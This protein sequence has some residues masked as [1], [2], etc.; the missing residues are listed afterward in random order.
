MSRMLALTVVAFSLFT[1]PGIGLSEDINFDEAFGGGQAVS[2]AAAAGQG[3]ISGKIV[4]EGAPAAE[5]AIKME[6]DPYCEI[7]HPTPI[8]PQEVVANAN[9]TLKNVFVYLKEGVSGSFPAPTDPVKFDQKNCW[10]DPHVFG[11]RVGQPIE[12]WNSDDTL[13]NVHSYPEK[14]TPFNLGMPVKGMKLQKTFTSPEVM[15]KIKCDVHPWMV[16]YA[17]VLDHPFFSVSG[18]EGA[19]ELKGVPA[20]TYTIEAWHEK[21]GMQTQQVTL[22]ADEAK[23]L[24]FTFKVA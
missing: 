4:L 16:A 5:T 23:T 3:A 11:I 18:A 15:V 6:A 24:D 7:Q 22:T 10:Y 21:L 13:H 19:F 2:G 20:G 12:I 17:G 1:F 8:T 14:S 9:G